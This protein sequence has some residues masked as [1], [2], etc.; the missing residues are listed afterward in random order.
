[1]L[2]RKANKYRI[3]PNKAQQ[4]AL[5]VQFGH[6]RSVYNYFLALRIETYQQIG[7]GLGYTETA[8]LLSG[9]KRDPQYE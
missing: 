8:N 3:Y 5:R 1:M 4:E 6:T 7:K 2:I 9:M